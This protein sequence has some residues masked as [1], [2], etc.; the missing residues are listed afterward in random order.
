VKGF[1]PKLKSAGVS[2]EWIRRLTVENPLR[3][4]GIRPH[5]KPPNK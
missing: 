5:A 1:I 3:V 4:F 2:D